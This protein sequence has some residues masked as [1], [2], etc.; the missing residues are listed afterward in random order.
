MT[1]LVIKMSLRIVRMMI[2]NKEPSEECLMMRIMRQQPFR[3]GYKIHWGVE[4]NQQ[5]QN[6][7]D[8]NIIIT[9]SYDNQRRKHNQF[10]R[11][12][13]NIIAWYD[14]NS[15]GWYGNIMI[16]IREEEEGGEWLCFAPNDNFFFF[17]SFLFFFSLDTSDV[18]QCIHQSDVSLWV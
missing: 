5:H 17:N 16:I 15:S 18:Q 6:H 3:D 2:P 8:H 1:W 10:I 12:S 4:S 13:R 7:H 14:A 9:A 11:S